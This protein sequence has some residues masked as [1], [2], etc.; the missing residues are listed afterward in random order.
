MEFRF[1]HHRKWWC[2][3]Y[4]WLLLYERHTRTDTGYFSCENYT[5]YRGSLEINVTDLNESFLIRWS[6][7][8]ILDAVQCEWKPTFYAEL[9]YLFTHVGVHD[10]YEYMWGT[11]E[12]T[13]NSRSVWSGKWPATA[14]V[15][16]VPHLDFALRGSVGLTGTSPNAS[17]LGARGIW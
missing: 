11:Y 12:V 10:M 5:P 8:E 14:C 9:V 7:F 1:G 17:R 15:P 13:A 4:M 2:H 3:F 16:A 6:G